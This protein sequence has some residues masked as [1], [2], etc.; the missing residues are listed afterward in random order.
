MTDKNTRSFPETQCRTQLA[1]L[2]EWLGA[3]TEDEA[4]RV[5]RELLN[6][7]NFLAFKYNFPIEKDKRVVKSKV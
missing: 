7:A 6:Q 1:G 2:R 4:K 3:L 5:Y